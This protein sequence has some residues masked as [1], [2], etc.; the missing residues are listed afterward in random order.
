MKKK[1]KVSTKKLSAKQVAVRAAFKKA[2]AKA[3][4]IQKANPDKKW[5]DCI[6]EANK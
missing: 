6:K 1:R 5:T 3:K 4:S 2:I